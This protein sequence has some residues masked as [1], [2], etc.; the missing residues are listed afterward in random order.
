LPR[1]DSIRLQTMRII[2]GAV[3]A[4]VAFDGIVSIIYYLHQHWYEHA[5]RVARIG[6]GLIVI[7]LAWILPR[8]LEGLIFSRQNIFLRKKFYG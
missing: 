3:G 6:C 2:L 4:W 5:V 8:V 7:L 1:K